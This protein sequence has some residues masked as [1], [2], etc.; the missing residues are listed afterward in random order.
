MP[1]A[2]LPF[3]VW[4]FECG[5]EQLFYKCVSLSLSLSLSLFFSRWGGCT[6][7]IPF[8]LTAT[9]CCST[10]GVADPDFWL[11]IPGA[12]SG[13]RRQAPGHLFPPLG[14]QDGRLSLVSSVPRLASLST[15]VQPSCIQLNS[16]AGPQKE[17][18]GGK[19]AQQGCHCIFPSAVGRHSGDIFTKETGCRS[20]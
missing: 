18:A 19:S 4:V 1:Q 9:T 7:T 3:S 11:L 6:V 10:M 2:A 16:G 5:V 20:V 13:L 17:E 15:L 8:N 14:T 12:G